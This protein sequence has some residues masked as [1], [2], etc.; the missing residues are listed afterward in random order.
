[1]PDVLA[2]S[3]HALIAVFAAVA[4]AGLV[5]GVLGLGFAIVATA[6]VALLTD[7]K[8]AIVVSL[9]P[10]LLITAINVVRGGNY[11]QSLGRY[12]FLP[13]YMIA[14]SFLGARLLLLAGPAP[15]TLL[16]ALVILAFLNMER[17]REGSWS[18]VARRPRLAGAAFGLVA[19]LSESTANVSAPPLL[20]YFLSLGTEPRALVQAI[21]LCFFAGKSTQ[22]LTLTASGGLQTDR[23]AATLP[24]AVVALVAMLLGSAVRERVDAAR[25]RRWL[26]ILLWVVAPLLLAQFVRQ[27]VPRGA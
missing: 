23:L 21:N 1:V 24:F 11:R 8:S 12:W 10:T 2:L 18:W 4:F 5:H 7:I 16:L 22:T 20:I 3:P 14:G 13:L 25:Y 17:L 27:V 19:G 26:R 6:L 9:L 15:F